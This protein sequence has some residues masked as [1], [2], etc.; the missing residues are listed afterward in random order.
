MK[1]ILISAITY[2]VIIK[3][4]LFVIIGWILYK[5]FIHP[6]VKV[7]GEVFVVIIEL[8][9][10]ILSLLL[11]LFKGVNNKLHPVL[12]NSQEHESV[13]SVVSTNLV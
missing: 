3:A 5:T 10:V 12:K 11:R 2:S 9:K 4:I 7:V 6:F 8:V 13:I 1:L